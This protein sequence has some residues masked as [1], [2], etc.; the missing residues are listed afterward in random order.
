MKRP[1]RWLCSVWMLATG[2]AAPSRAA[3]LQADFVDVA[4]TVPW[5]LV[6]LRYATPVNFASQVLYPPG[7]G[8]YLRRPVAQQL[9]QAALELHQDGLRLKLWDCYRPHHVQRLLWQRVP[10]P[11][12]VANPAQGSRH[13]RGAAVDVTLTD[14]DGVELPMPTPFDEFGPR[15]HRDYQDLPAPVLKNRARL[16]Q[17][18]RRAGFVPLPTEWWH[19]D[20]AS[21]RDHPIADVSFADLQTPR[22]TAGQTF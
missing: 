6:E 19:F 16:E 20:S 5:V 3:A 22:K 7:A 4:R 15:A 2:C 13:N 18:M 10:D 17:A 21:F 12:Y 8:C 9:T 11:R 14:L 1:A